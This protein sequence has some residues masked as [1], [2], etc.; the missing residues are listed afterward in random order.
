MHDLSN[1]EMLAVHGGK[2]TK[3]SLNLKKLLP[4]VHIK[5]DGNVAIS[6]NLAEVTGTGGATEIVQIAE[7]AAGT[8][9]V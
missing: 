5:T 4:G 1:S 3:D 7:S 6:V 8:V 9:S 2:H